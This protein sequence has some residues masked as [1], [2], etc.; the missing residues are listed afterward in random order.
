[1]TKEKG[2][3]NTLL[4]QYIKNWQLVMLMLPGVV[5][6]FLFHYVPMAGVI[7]AF[8]DYKLSEGIF[9]SAWCGFEN[10]EIL[11]M[12]ENFLKILKNTL[13][14]SLGKLLIG[15]PMPIILALLLNEVTNKVFKRGVQTFSYLPHFFSW[16]VLG[17]IMT[18]LFRYNGPINVILTA[19]GLDK[20][21]FFGSNGGFLALIFGSHVWQS[22]GWGSI[23][24]LSALSAVDATLYEAAEIDGAS[25]WRQTW[26][27][28]LPGIRPTVIVSL[29]LAMGGVLTA[30][31][32]QIY[33][34][35]NPTVYGV[36]DVIDTFTQRKLETMDF[37]TGTAV[38]LFKS[39]VSLTL[40]LITNAVTKR[41]N[42]N[43]SA[44]F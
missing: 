26:H 19:V 8:K 22:A 34:L 43:E 21:D 32:D 11:F 25:R 37:A 3:R 31:F 30:G 42:D 14:I 15:F 40:V 7:V 24:Y 35:Y 5:C 9:G 28:T 23:L 41:L 6:L 29:V 18:Q 10:F 33:N 44:L 38:G 36:A 4:F 16:V 27:I 13:V 12:G 17:G 2:F 20:I 39:V 1:M